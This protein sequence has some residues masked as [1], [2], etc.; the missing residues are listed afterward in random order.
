MSKTDEK[1]L[2]LIDF[3]L[4]KNFFEGAPIQPGVASPG[5]PGGVPGSPAEDISKRPKRQAK[6]MKTKAGTVGRF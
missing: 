1:C 4:S 5:I 6:V 3:G 2:K